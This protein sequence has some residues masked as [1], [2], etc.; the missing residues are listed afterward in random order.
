MSDLRP[1]SFRG[2]RFDVDSRSITV[3]RRVVLHEYPQRSIPYAEDLGRKARRYELDALIIGADYDQR[4]D[5]LIRALEEPGAGELVHPDYGTLWVVVPD[6]AKITQRREEIGKAELSL[7]FVEAGEA[8]F[9]SFT[10]DAESVLADA[11]GA[12]V[13]AAMDAFAGSFDVT[14][15]SQAQDVSLKDLIAAFKNMQNALGGLSFSPDDLLNLLPFPA[16]LAL[17]IA[18]S[19]VGGVMNAQLAIATTVSEWKRFDVSGLLGL[20]RLQVLKRS[21]GGLPSGMA[22]TKQ[23]QNSAALDALM[24]GVVTATLV[25]GYASLAF[26]SVEESDAAREKIASVVDVALY[27]GMVDVDTLIQQ[28]T[29]AMRYIN[30]SSV[31]IPQLAKLQLKQTQPA[32]VVAYQQQGTVQYFEDFIAR[33]HIVHPGFVPAGRELSLLQV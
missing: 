31:S 24:Q 30:A 7:T 14:G 23:S 12:A 16:K 13:Q 27:D 15:D 18:N 17:A 26:P 5:Q 19:I 33:N 20:E 8:V 2:V 3:G 25:Q 11:S 22:L 9:P 4:R 10:Q 6:D 21:N 32:L 28:R 1:A 29:A